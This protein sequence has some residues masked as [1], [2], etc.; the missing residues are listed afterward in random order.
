MLNTAVTQRAALGISA[1]ALDAIA[2]T[3]AR[4]QMLTPRATVEVALSGGKDSLF[5]ML[6]LRE[7]GYQVR[8]VIVDM[9]YE[10]GWGARIVQLAK[11]LSFDDVSVLSVRDEAFMSLL[12]ESRLGSIR[13]NLRILD[14]TDYSANRNLTP[15]TQC[16]NTKALSLQTYLDR[17]GSGNIAFGHHATDAVASFLKSAL[18][19]I[20]RWDRGHET[21]DRENYSALVDEAA[22]V[23]C[24]P[25]DVALSST[26]FARLETLAAGSMATTDEPPVQHLRDAGS[27]A[28][29]IRPLFTI[30]ER[31]ISDF[32]DSVALVTE[33]SGC[34]HGATK[35]SETPR[36]MVHFRIL[37]RL[38]EAAGSRSRLMAALLE[39]VQHGIAKDGT[40][41]FNARNM[42]DSLLGPGYRAGIGCGAKL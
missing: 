29:I 21:Y 28:L 13:T 31:D 5:T 19:Y 10:A 6:A 3:I 36:E 26:L 8:G 7:L 4:Y 18:M 24:Q 35:D 34:G 39:L 37:A 2:E 40:L 22:E 17:S 38:Q 27:T 1:R 42:R 12:P 30:D 9:G 11:S 32:R 20:D 15:C 23:L 41:L 14:T 16:Y 33:G 25:A